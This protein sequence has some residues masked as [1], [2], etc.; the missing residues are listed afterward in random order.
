[1]QSPAASAKRLE[2]F[3]KVGHSKGK[4]NP[5]YGATVRGTTTGEK[6]SIA[7]KEQVKF[8]KE[9]AIK[10]NAKNY[11]CEYC[12]KENLSVG[13]YKRWHHANCQLRK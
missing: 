11:S 10:L 4:K 2:T 13:N 12:G 8:N 5:R 1:M 9:K 3:S 7:R 6:I